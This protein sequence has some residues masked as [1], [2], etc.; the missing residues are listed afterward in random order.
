MSLDSVWSAWCTE[1][2]PGVFYVTPKEYE[3]LAVLTGKRPNILKTINVGGRV[4]LNVLKDTPISHKTWLPSDVPEE[5]RDKPEIKFAKIIEEHKHKCWFLDAWK[6]SSDY[7]KKHL[8]NVRYIGEHSKVDMRD[9]DLT[10]TTMVIIALGLAWHVDAK[11]SEG[12]SEDLKT[13]AMNL[14]EKFHLEAEDHHPQHGVFNIKRLTVDRFSVHLQKMENDGK[15]GGGMGMDWLTFK[16]H[17]DPDGKKGKEAQ[18]FFKTF[19]DDLKDIDAY[20]VVNDD[21]E[22]TKKVEESFSNYIHEMLH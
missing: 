13:E 11:S 2:C 12:Y 20:A 9:H 14:V 15:N 4:T 1:L 17:E 19:V 16:D 8:N 18:E 6:K 5:I 22:E 7:T 10:K 3:I 21:P